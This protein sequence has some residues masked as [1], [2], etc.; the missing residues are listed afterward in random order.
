[1]NIL[2]ATINRGKV[3]L[4][5]LRGSLITVIYNNA[6]CDGLFTEQEILTGMAGPEVFEGMPRQLAEREYRKILRNFERATGKKFLGKD[7]APDKNLS[8]EEYEGELIGFLEDAQEGC[9]DAD[10]WELFFP[11]DAAYEERM[12]YAEILG[13]CSGMNAWNF[14]LED[15]LD[16][17]SAADD[18]DYEDFMDEALDF[19]RE[20]FIGFVRDMRKMREEA[21]AS[22]E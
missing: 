20:N 16:Y 18:E 12:T 15:L 17:D 5:D 21:E 14:W 10:D 1:M 4:A 3:D 2:N 9:W 6:L 22:E 11:K 7:L 13:Y 19:F 8:K